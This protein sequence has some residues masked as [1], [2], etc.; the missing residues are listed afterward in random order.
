MNQARPKQDAIPP[1]TKII[2]GTGDW[3]MASFNTLHQIFYAIFLTDVVGL[4][5]RLASFAAFFGGVL[6]FLLIYWMAGATWSP[7][8]PASTCRW[9]RSCWD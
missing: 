9:N 6:P 2:Y 4:E 1:L 7:P 8:F 3:G 5:P